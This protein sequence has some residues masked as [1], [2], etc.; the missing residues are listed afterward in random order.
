LSEQ[1]ERLLS[2]FEDMQRL[3]F[4]HLARLTTGK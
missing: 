1:S 3:H 4:E 2:N